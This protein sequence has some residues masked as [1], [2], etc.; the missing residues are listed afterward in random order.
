MNL[1]LCEPY[2]M[3]FCV[4]VQEQN[5]SIQEPWFLSSN[6]GS[7]FDE[8]EESKDNYTFASQNTVVITFLMEG[9]TLKFLFLGNCHASKFGTHL[10]DTF[11]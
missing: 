2:Y 9:D 1:I 11:R 8:G 7:E 6:G 3:W 5:T 10:A 4:V